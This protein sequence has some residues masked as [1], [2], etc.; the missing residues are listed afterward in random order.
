MLASLALRNGAEKVPMPNFLQNL[1]CNDPLGCSEES[2]G[3]L[4]SLQ[5]EM[6]DLVGEMHDVLEDVS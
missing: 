6:T 3:A 4:E 5:L 1:A 2:L